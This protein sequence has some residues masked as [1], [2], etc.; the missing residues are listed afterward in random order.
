MPSSGTPVERTAPAFD[1]QRA[2]VL[3][4]ATALGTPGVWP[5]RIVLPDDREGGPRSALSPSRGEV[6][7]GHTKTE[8]GER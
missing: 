5:S 6:A 4:N 1:A 8:G 2:R 7:R 3:E